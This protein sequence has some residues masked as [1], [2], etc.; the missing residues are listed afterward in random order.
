MAS[1]TFDPVAI[2]HRGKTRRSAVTSRPGPAPRPLVAEI[3][4]TVAGLGFGICLAL[5][6][7]AESFKQLSATGGVLMFLGNLTGLAGTYLALIMVLLI[8]RVPAVERVLVKTSCWHCT[9]SW[10]PGRYRSSSDMGCSSR[11]RTPK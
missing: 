11:S 3:A 2:S 7:T 8:S 9:A 1:V 4:T 10:R 5:A 6:V